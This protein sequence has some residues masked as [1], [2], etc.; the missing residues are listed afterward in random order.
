MHPFLLSLIAIF[1]LYFVAKW[2][3]RPRKKLPP[4]PPKLPILGNLHQLS[5]LSHHSFQSLGR[6]YGPLM[7]V[8]F[9]SRPTIIVQSADAASEI[10]RTNDL[11][12]ANRV[13]SR[14]STRIFYDTRDII[15][16][17]YGE[18]WRKLKSVCI[19]QLLSSK[20]VQSFNFIREEETALLEKRIKSCCSSGSPVNLSELFMSLANHVTCRA[21]FG[22]KYSDGEGGKKFLMLL[23]EVVELL[24]IVLLSE[25]LFHGFRGLIVLMVSIIELKRL[26]KKWMRSWI[27]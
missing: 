8:H 1:S 4:S 14:S 6:R 27:W 12:F 11:I 15:T 13:G 19:L 25:N 20:R 17:P 2:L 23:T 9:G 16:A 5:T 24:G 3:Y 10:M 7:L 18:Y 22:R 26:Q 21:T